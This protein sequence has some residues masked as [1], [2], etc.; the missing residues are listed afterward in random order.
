MTFARCCL[1]KYGCAIH[2]SEIYDYFNFYNEEEEEEGK[3]DK[4]EEE[5]EEESGSED[6]EDEDQEVEIQED[7]FVKKKT[8]RKTFGGAGGKGAASKRWFQE[9]QYNGLKESLP[10]LNWFHGIITRR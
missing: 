1:A 9:T 4:K 10:F 8:L 7:I 3:E 6:E 5:E 2:Q